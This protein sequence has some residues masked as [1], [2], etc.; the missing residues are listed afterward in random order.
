MVEEA[1]KPGSRPLRGKVNND[2]R[3]TD[4]TASSDGVTKGEPWKRCRFDRRG[5]VPG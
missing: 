2:I 4:T 5:G 1:E 3:A